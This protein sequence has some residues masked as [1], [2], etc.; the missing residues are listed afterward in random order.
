MNQIKSQEKPTNMK[1][2]TLESQITKSDLISHNLRL[3]PMTKYL[4]SYS[5]LKWFK[6]KLINL[7][8]PIY[9]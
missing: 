6:I 2:Y 7:N 1:H 3:Y 5:H 8:Y 4:E 9:P